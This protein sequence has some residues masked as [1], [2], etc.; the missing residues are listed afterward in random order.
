MA[1][2]GIFHRQFMQIEL[3]LEIREF[4]GL[5]VF[6]RDPEKTFRAAAVGAD[7]RRR[8]LVGEPFAVLISD[9]IDEHEDPFGGC[10]AI[11]WCRCYGAGHGSF[12]VASGQTDFHCDATCILWRGRGAPP[13]MMRVR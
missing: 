2:A 5:R 1:V 4:A 6:Q 10:C 8:E 13:A 9:A 12:A 3:F 7:G 11:A